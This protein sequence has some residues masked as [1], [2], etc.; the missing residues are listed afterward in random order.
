MLGPSDF[1]VTRQADRI[2]PGN[3]RRKANHGLR[4]RQ[5]PP[6][7]GMRLERVAGIEPAPRAWKARVIPFHHTRASELLACAAGGLKRQPTAGPKPQPGGA[8]ARPRGPPPRWIS[9]LDRTRVDSFLWLLRLP[10]GRVLR[11]PAQRFVQ[12][13]WK[14]VQAAPVACGHAKG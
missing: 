8:M 5:L 7:I 1:P 9:G 14:P 2:S 4:S 13:G 11:R 12:A 3:R 10:E 6:M